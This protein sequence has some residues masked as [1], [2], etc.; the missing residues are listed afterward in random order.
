MP[1]PVLPPLAALSL[2]EIERLV[3]AR[4]LPP[5]AQWC[6]QQT[7][8]SAMRIAA[9]GSWHHEGRPLGRPAMVRALSSLLLQDAAGAHWLMT[10]SCR[11][12]IEV[13]DAAF[14]A[15]DMALRGETL[16][17]A[18]NT[19]ELILAGPQNPLRAAGAADCPA[20]YLGVRHGCE[21]RLNR[22]TW[23]MLAEHALAR[24]G[25]ARE[26]ALAVC[27]GGRRFSLVPR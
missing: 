26:D 6:P 15:V 9:D 17:F 27:S 12:R 5:V 7:I 14:V 4:R 19:D 23:L 20:I 1:Y 8:D 3:A 13:E 24:P 21:A 11:Q 2:A 22:A 10:P 18:L 25:G 16:V